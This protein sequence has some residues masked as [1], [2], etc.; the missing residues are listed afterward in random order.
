MVNILEF[1]VLL[2]QAFFSIPRRDDLPFAILGQ[3]QGPPVAAIPDA[4]LKPGPS[5]IH[6]HGME[7]RLKV[8]SVHIRTSEAVP[9]SMVP[10]E[11][12][13]LSVVFKLLL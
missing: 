9:V 4:A 12:K 10:A 2:H 6:H 13:L 8:D 1:P 7:R 3:E 11:E 5:I